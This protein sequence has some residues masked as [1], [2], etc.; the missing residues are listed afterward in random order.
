MRDEELV[1]AYKAGDL[2]ALDTI[3]QNYKEFVSYKA[4]CFYIMGGDTQDLFQDGMLGLISAVGSYDPE[5]N[6]SFFPFASMCITRSIYK[7]IESASRKKNSPLN[8]YVLM[9]NEDGE[10]SITT[11]MGGNASTNPETLLLEEE[12]AKLIEKSIR[13]VLS[14]KELKVFELCLKG[15]SYTTIA[16]ML[17]ISPKS[18]DNTIQR[19][20]SK[21]KKVISELD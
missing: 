6:D 1:M 19:I 21:A 10:E 9:Y 3:C 20:R 13:E 14:E 18:A 11:Y 5:K 16:D 17:G 2:K 15:E 8:D 4:K 12:G 7:S